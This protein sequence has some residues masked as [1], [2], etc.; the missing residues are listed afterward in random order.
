MTKNKEK[1]SSPSAY[2]TQ[3]MLSSAYNVLTHRSTLAPFNT[4]D[5]TPRDLTFCSLAAHVTS[6]PQMVSQPNMTSQPEGASSAIQVEQVAPPSS[7]ATSSTASRDES[8]LLDHL[9]ASVMAHLTNSSYNQL[10]S[11]SA[12]KVQVED[13]PE[14]KSLTTVVVPNT[15]DRYLRETMSEAGY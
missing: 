11:G 2:V 3:E 6:A 5:E 14:M 15:S 12:Q 13:I 1:F 4:P 10:A 9:P 7:A 8:K